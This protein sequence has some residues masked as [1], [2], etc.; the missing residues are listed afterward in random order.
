M[1][2]SRPKVLV[3]DDEPRNVELVRRTLA[4]R[5]EVL[6]ADDGQAAMERLREN[7]DVVLVLSDQRMAPVTGTELLGYART[8]APHALRAIITGYS[9]RAAILEAINLSGV[10]R[11]LQKPVAPADI[12]RLADEAV[13]AWSAAVAS[14]L[15]SGAEKGSTPVTLDP[16]TGA[17][18]WTYF[19]ERAGHEIQRARRYDRPLSLLFI[20]VDYFRGFNEAHG[21]AAGDRL[22]AD[23]AA[24]LMG[25]PGQPGVL[26]AVDLVGRLGGGCFA[27][28]VPETDGA[29]AVV[30]AE[31]IRAA[32]ASHQFVGR[33][34]QPGGKLTVSIGVASFPR[35]AEDLDA[36]MGA[37]DQALAAAK[38][39]GHDRAIRYESS[40]R[41][42]QVSL[43]EPDYRRA[44]LEDLV[45]GQRAKFVFQPIVRLADQQVVGYEALCRPDH[46][47]FPDPLSLFRTAERTGAITPLSR[48]LRG[49]LAETLSE[50]PRETLLFVNLH[51]QEFQDPELL[52]RG[53]PLQPWARQIVF[54]ITEMAALWDFDDAHER[55]GRL[56]ELGCAFAL[57][58]VG[59]GYSGLRS[60]ARLAP[61]FI[62]LD[63][64]LIGS[65]S[66]DARAARLMRHLVDFA[67]G[68][69]IEVVAEGI[70]EPDQ[71]D[72]LEDLGISLV[73]GYFFGRPAAL[74][75]WTDGG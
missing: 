66:G 32:L 35:D 73:Q 51:P 59:A 36:L 39:C 57:D 44:G 75:H 1:A 56:R 72:L 34:S 74:Q 50:L 4:R 53:C 8:I 30:A 68:E 6:T 5:F 67:V 13:E 62:K 61:Q 65:L 42:S 26:R 45:R 47:L 54:E 48:M 33:E 58:D 71:I 21:H 40:E 60:L 69:G 63:K 7:R 70:E 31:R 17:Q 55:M 9:D 52:A 27:A 12:E 43:P 25:S 49:V 20:G 3:V 14:S 10:H 2:E 23:V 64:E 41:A 18:S 22:L 28:L 38:S 15:R 46:P 16:I 37:A 24:L 29:G 19:I 11:Y